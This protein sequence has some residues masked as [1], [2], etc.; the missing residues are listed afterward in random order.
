M[1][2]SCQVLLSCLYLTA[3]T[4]GSC[5]YSAA[6]T[7]LSLLKSPTQ[8]PLLSC[9]ALLSC[10]YSAA[11]TQLP[12]LSCPYSAVRPIYSAARHTYSET[13]IGRSMMGCMKDAQWRVPEL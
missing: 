2:L 11:P 8:L 4:Q 12:L 13:A 6:P 9:Q 5:P 10:P 1:G 7:Q 3:P